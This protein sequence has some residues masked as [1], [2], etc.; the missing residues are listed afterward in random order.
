[1]KMNKKNIVLVMII[2]LFISIFINSNENLALEVKEK[3]PHTLVAHAGGAIY[4]YKYTNSLEALEEAYKNGFKLIELDFQWTTDGKIVCIHDWESMTRRL[5]MINY[6]PLS[7][8]EFKSFN[9]FQGLTLM[10]VNDLAEWLRNKDDVYIITDMKGDNIRFLKELKESY[11]DIQDRFIPQIYSF[12]EYWAVRDMG[13]EDIILTLYKTWYSDSQ[14]VNFVKEH[15]LFALTMA[16]ERA[17]TNLPQALKEVDITIYA[18]T[19][20]EL[21]EFENLF[22]NGVHGIYTDYF[23]PNNFIK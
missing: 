13:Y 9:T 6:R 21:Y 16:S 7:L 20:N 10:D 8:E 17:Q 23:Q 11:S 22:R 19:V 1:M 18:H 12:D 14:I 3:K 4:G 15:E 2:T 5:F